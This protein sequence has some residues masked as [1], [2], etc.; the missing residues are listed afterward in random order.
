MV[1]KSVL[2]IKYFFLSPVL[3]KYSNFLKSWRWL[4]CVDI[5]LLL[6]QRFSTKSS[7]VVPCLPVRMMYEKILAATGAICSFFSNKIPSFSTSS[8][9]L[10]S[11]E[12]ILFVYG[13]KLSFSS[14]HSELIMVNFFLMFF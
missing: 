12:S 2:M 8:R 1:L 4:R 7:K 14:Q 9:F 11:V 10:F 3:V 5:V 6:A 13:A